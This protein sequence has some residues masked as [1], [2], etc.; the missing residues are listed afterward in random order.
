M[1]K[2]SSIIK[3]NTKIAIL[4]FF[5]CISL[6]FLVKNPN[7]FEASVLNIWEI[8]FIDE[9]N[10]DIAYKTTWDV[11]DIFVSNSLLST[12]NLDKLN[13]SIAY[14]P[15]ISLSDKNIE[16]QTDYKIISSGDNSIDIEIWLSSWVDY[17]KSILIIPFS[18]NNSR[19]LIQD[20]Y[21]LLSDWTKQDLSVWNLTTQYLHN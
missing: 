19:I 3:R 9:N 2:I 10:W 6:V 11:L 4:S 5:V 7:L 8:S 21:G 18:W 13:I 15:S 20:A 17:K 16:Y 12:K 1:A 14:D